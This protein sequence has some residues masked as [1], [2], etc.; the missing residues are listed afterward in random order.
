MLFK[1]GSGVVDCKT[2]VLVII[3]AAVSGTVPL[4]KTVLASP[5]ANV[6]KSRLPVHGVNVPP[7]SIENSGFIILIG[8]L[9]VNTTFSAL[10]GPLFVTNIV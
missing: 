5:E 10:S 9:S 4:I 8:I 1:S 2:A 3:P 7:S 6:P